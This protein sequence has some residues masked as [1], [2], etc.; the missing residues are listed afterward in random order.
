MLL[1]EEII[2]QA[3]RLPLGDRAFLADTLEQ[4]LPHSD[5]TSLEV[6]AACSEEIDR[7]IAACDRGDGESAQESTKSHIRIV[8]ADDHPMF[9]RVL[10]HFLDDCYDLEVVAEADSGDAAEQLA[11]EFKPDVV[12][13]DY[14][15]SGTDS[16]AATRRIVHDLPQ[17][18]VIG[19]SS[20]TDAEDALI[21][22]GAVAFVNK[23]SANMYLI[24]EAIRSVA[25]SA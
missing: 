10:V 20:D 18:R 12:L 19:I 4:S 15:M 11:Q 5:F 6:A 9:R 22:A 17:V 7:R 23:A 16:S 14:H 13:M 3:L 24:C 8:V 25:Q 21:S 2:Q 1:R